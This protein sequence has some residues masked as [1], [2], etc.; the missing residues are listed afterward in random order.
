MNITRGT[1]HIP[2]DPTPWVLVS[3]NDDKEWCV[4]WLQG[5]T[6]TIEGHLEGIT[7]MSEAS[8]VSFAMMDYAG[9]GT[10]PTPLNDSTR[11]QQFTECLAAYDELVT[12]GYQ[13]IIVIGGSFGGYMAA[14]LTGQRKPTATVLR[15]A[16]IYRDEEFELP[17]SQ[18]ARWDERFDDEITFRK[19]VTKD[20]PLAALDAIHA[21][22]GPVW[23][24]EH[25]LDTVVPG[26]VIRAYFDAAKHGNYILVR[27]T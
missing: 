23:A 1:L 8:G 21:Y 17:S 25:E 2:N 27:G 7:R 12:Q 16:A 5:W 13:N 10:H 11:A 9:H 14:L 4:L 24:M 26:N 20:S 19:S 3:P 22:D 18:T 15:A 6:S